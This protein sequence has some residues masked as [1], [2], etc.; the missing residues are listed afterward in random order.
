MLQS[1]TGM[2]RFQ[3][4]ARR[5]ARPASGHRSMKRLSLL[6]VLALVAAPLS[7]QDTTK[8]PTAKVAGNWDFNFT[9]PQGTANWRIKFEQ[10]GDTLYGTA[11]TDFGAVNVSDG[12]VTGNDISFTLNLNVQGTAISVNFAG[13]V[14]G[15]TASGQ[16][17]VPNVGIQPFPF[18]AVRAAG[19]FASV[20]ALRSRTI[21]AVR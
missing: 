4:T 13:T 3:P 15:D 2:T 6:A 21:T 7:A 1:S 14:K 11:N 17:D 20:Y 19:E 12:W 18:T 10:S 8:T 5:K 16:I 9:S